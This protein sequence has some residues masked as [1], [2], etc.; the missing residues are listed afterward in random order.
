MVARAPTEEV[1]RD[2]VWLEQNVRNEVGWTYDMK[3][4]LGS[5]GL[6]FSVLRSH[7]HFIRINLHSLPFVFSQLGLIFND[8]VRHSG[9]LC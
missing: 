4:R 6:S 2:A 7:Q 5:L 8:D 9:Q 1:T 3:V